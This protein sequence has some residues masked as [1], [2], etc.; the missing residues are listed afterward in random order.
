MESGSAISQLGRS[1]RAAW[2]CRWPSLGLILRSKPTGKFGDVDD[3][4]FMCAFADQFVFSPCRHLELH[5][6]IINRRDL[7]RERDERS[8]WSRH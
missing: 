1:V 6:P 8:D 2:G 3:R 5:P 4:S 7:R